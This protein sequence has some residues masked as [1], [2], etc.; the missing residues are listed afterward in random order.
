MERMDWSEAVEFYQR[1]VEASEGD[2]PD[3]KAHAEEE[4][5]KAMKKKTEKRA[6]STGQTSPP[7]ER[8]S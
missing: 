5:A 7:A 6:G 1:A 8:Y 3:L 4:L 2:A